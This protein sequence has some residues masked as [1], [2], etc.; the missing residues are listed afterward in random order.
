MLLG[1]PEPLQ[2]DRRGGVAPYGLWVLAEHLRLEVARRGG[3]HRDAVVGPGGGELAREPLDRGARGTRVRHAGQPVMRRERDVD[4]RPAAGR[5]HRPL[6]RRLGHAQRPV[7]VEAPHGVPAL[8]LDRLGGGEVLA[9]GV[10]DEQIQPAVAL[11]HGVHEPGRVGVLADVAGRRRAALADVG[12]CGLEDLGP[13][14]GQ[15]DVGAT[16]RQL[17]SRGP[18]EPGPSTG[19]QRRPSGQHVRA[20]DLGGERHGGPES[21]RRAS[22]SGVARCARRRPPSRC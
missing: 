11:E 13:P 6:G 14:P 9:A 5:P 2:R 1:S 16:G 22:T 7:D 17:A 18:P 3:D 10:V 15:H 21:M 12:G 8:G 20:E 4:D 19:D